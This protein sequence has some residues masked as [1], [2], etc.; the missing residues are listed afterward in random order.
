MITIKRIIKSAWTNFF[1]NTSLSFVAVFVV[2]LT[3]ILT[4]SIFIIRDFGYTVVSDIQDK[5]SISLYFKEGV[6]EVTVLEVQEEISVLP[7]VI[8]TQYISTDQ[9]LEEFIER[10]RDNPVIMAGVAE[11]GDQFLRPT[12]TIKSDSIE[13]YD[14]IVAF[15]ETSSSRIFFDKIDYERRRLVIENIFAIISTTTTIG[16]FLAVT[17][18]LIAVLIVISIIRLSVYGMKEEI[19][20]LKLVGVS[21]RFINSSFIAQGIIIGLIA[22]I[23]SFVFVF[24][25]GIFFNDNLNILIPGFNFMDYLKNNFLFLLILQFGVGITLA[26]FSSILAT[27]RYLKR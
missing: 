20:V 19:E 5:L 18:G 22:F 8:S 15:L 6:D 9:A 16:I 27:R 3:I 14:R 1:R 11:I 24:G 23:L 21:K 17:L 25:L 13:G 2:F 12:I 4:T 10:H 26:T 7:D